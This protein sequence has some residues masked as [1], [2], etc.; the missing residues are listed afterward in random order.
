M[1]SWTTIVVHNRDDQEVGMAHKVK[2]PENQPQF[3][4]MTMGQYWLGKTKPKQAFRSTQNAFK[5][6]LRNLKKNLFN[7]IFLLTD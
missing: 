6:L 3:S 4:Q 5:K 7:G 2:S 1:V